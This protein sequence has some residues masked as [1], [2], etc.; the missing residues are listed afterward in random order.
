M[1]IL[2]KESTHHVNS[3]IGPRRR[4]QQLILFC[5]KKWS[6]SNQEGCPCQPRERKSNGAA[7]MEKNSGFETKSAG[8]FKQ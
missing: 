2:V 1:A 3:G 8:Q 5:L 7:I 4:E 6:S